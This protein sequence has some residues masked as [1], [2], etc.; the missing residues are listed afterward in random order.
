MKSI[1]R[2]TKKKPR[3][4]SNVLTFPTLIDPFAPD[5]YLDKHGNLEIKEWIIGTGGRAYLYDAEAHEVS[6]QDEDGN[7]IWTIRRA[8]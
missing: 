5:P 2:Q 4:R 1:T 8:A 3:T 6:I 7:I